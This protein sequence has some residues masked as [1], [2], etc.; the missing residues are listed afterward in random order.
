MSQPE[1]FQFKP[2]TATQC[3]TEK[4]ISLPGGFATVMRGPGFIC[5]SVIFH[6]EQVA[7]DLVPGEVERLE[8]EGLA[9]PI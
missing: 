3:S 2:C 7:Q 1:N 5:D 8:Q 6:T 9:R 4:E